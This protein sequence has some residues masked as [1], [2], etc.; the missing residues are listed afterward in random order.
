MRGNKQRKDIK[1]G[2]MKKVLTVFLVLLAFVVLGCAQKKVVQP[3][4]AEE[5]AQKAP[6]KGAEEVTT[7]TKESEAVGQEMAKVESETMEGK[8]KM[9]APAFEDIHFD[10]DKYNITEQDKP[11]LRGLADWLVNNSAKVLVEGYCDDRGTNE[12]NLALGDRRAESVKDFLV[13][14]GVPGKRIETVSYG[15][16]KPL[17][18]EQTESCWARNRRAHFVIVE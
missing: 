7:E 17:C 14:S 16:G 10:F 5:M 18:T 6:E 2:L 12:Y 15:E 13:A 1:G 8:A 9:G 4:A 11:T 3:P